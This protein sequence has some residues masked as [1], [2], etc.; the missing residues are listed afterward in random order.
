[1]FLFYVVGKE[2][3]IGFSWFFVG[4]LPLLRTL[5]LKVS[6]VVPFCVCE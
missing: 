6:N 2:D 1:M 4:T 3:P 5:L